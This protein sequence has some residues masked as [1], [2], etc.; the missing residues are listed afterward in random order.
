MAADISY[1][2]INEGSNVEQLNLRV[3]KI[4]HKNWENWFLAKGKY[5]N[6]KNCEKC[7]ISNGRIISELS[8]FEAKVWFSILTF[9]RNSLIFQFG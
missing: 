4:G 7:G 3:T 5:E 9:L 2:K 8:I 6:W 1:L